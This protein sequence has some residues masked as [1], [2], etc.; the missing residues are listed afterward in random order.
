MVHRERADDAEAQALV[1][2]TVESQ[3]ALRFS[4]GDW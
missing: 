4:L 3:R 2:Q 1:N